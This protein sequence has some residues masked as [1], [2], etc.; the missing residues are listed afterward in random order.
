MARDGHESHDRRHRFLS[1]ISALAFCGSELC[2]NILPAVCPIRF[3]FWA[4]FAACSGIASKI[5]L[6]EIRRNP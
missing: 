6:A 3:G 1:W 2:A 4:Q 5:I